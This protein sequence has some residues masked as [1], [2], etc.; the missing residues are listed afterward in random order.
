MG[1]LRPFFRDQKV[2]VQGE[3]VFLLPES[4]VT[5]GKPAAGKA[6][7]HLER[8]PATPLPAEV[9]RGEPQGRLAVERTGRITAEGEARLAQHA[10]G[11]AAPAEQA[12]EGFEL[13]ARRPDRDRGRGLAPA[14]RQIAAHRAAKNLRLHRQCQLTGT[15]EAGLKIVDADSLPQDQVR[16]IHRAILPGRHPFQR[17][18]VFR[19][20]THVDLRRGRGK[21]SQRLLAEFRRKILEEIRLRSRQNLETC[22]AHPDGFRKKREPRGLARRFLRSRGLRRA[23]RFHRGG[24]SKIEH[25]AQIFHR[26]EADQPALPKE[27]PPW[28]VQRQH[29][30]VNLRRR[31]GCLGIPGPQT[32]L[33]CHQGAG[34]MSLDVADF[35][36]QPRASGLPGQPI[37]HQRFQSQRMQKPPRRQQDKGR[38]QGKPP[39]KPPWA[40]GG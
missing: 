8:F 23:G 22:P 35:Q 37:S 28:P 9:L 31:A 39:R 7:P 21:S 15:R 5:H 36:L 33:G 24:G 13:R 2:A 18:E 27:S 17:A 6:G 26:G 40:T 30:P 19:Q 32:D 16:Q 38:Q 12:D 14:Q 10:I 29:H 34:Q 11:F 1:D 20:G 4:E 25:P 3:G